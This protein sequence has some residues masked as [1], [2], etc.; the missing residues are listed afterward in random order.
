[1]TTIKL[2][3]SP[4]LRKQADYV[5][6]TL[7]A[8]RFVLVPIS[9]L[10]FYYDDTE[11][12]EK[13]AEKQKDEEEGKDEELKTE[14]GNSQADKITKFRLRERNS[15]MWFWI[16]MAQNFIHAA[17]VLYYWFVKG[18]IKDPP[19]RMIT[20]FYYFQLFFLTL[21]MTTILFRRSDEVKPLLTCPF[22][23]ENDAIRQVSK[24][25]YDLSTARSKLG[26]V[27]VS[28][29][30]ILLLTFNSY[31]AFTVRTLFS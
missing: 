27:H 13:Q 15:T 12:E 9:F 10:P 18:G 28:M 19:W 3:L 8:C 31:V 26:G 1:M 25:G 21:F 23:M 29:I 16:C 30:T 4:E 5:G 24:L 14:D 11:E 7:G 6:I 22:T 20:T 2:F 17:P